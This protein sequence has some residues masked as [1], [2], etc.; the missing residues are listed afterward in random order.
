MKQ[1]DGFGFGVWGVA[2]VVDVPVESETTKDGK[3]WRSVNRMALVA[4]RDFAA[5]AN[6]GA[7]LLTP[8][9]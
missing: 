2:G 6:A 8:D 9:L 7:G 4:G 1:D 5:V 3:T